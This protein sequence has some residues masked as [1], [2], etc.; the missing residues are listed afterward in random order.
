[1][2]VRHDMEGQK[3]SQ[4]QPS[5]ASLLPAWPPDW[6]E[7][8]AAVEV[9]LREGTWG[10]YRGP[11]ALE[12]RRVLASI[13]RES[14]GDVQQGVDMAREPDAEHCRLVSSGSLGVEL[15][16]RGLGIQAGD[17]VAVCGYD[18]PG[19]V[20]A[21]EAAGARPVLI[22]ADPNGNSLCP[23]KLAKMADSRPQDVQAV[24]VSHL[25]GVPAH[26]AEIS[27]ICRQ[28]EWSLVEDACQ[29]PGGIIE[30]R[31]AGGWGD[32]GVLSFGGSKPLTAGCGGA[33][34][35]K[36][37]QIH[38]R[39]NRWCDRPSDS[40]ALSEMQATLLLPQLARLPECDSIRHETIQA[41]LSQV[42]WTSS[43]LCGPPPSITCYKLAWLIDERER[44]VN[45]LIDRGIPAGVGYRS[46]HRSR[47]FDR[48][49]SLRRSIELG[50]RVVVLDHRALLAEGDARTWLL[51]QLIEVGKKLQL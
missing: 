2:Q 15:A 40:T 13:T 29:T 25:Y 31:P 17:R 24:I 39:L 33:L 49:E 3:Q 5:D 11:A 38:S 16:L 9:A 10:R 45:E 12:L 34:I 1:M 43:R 23:R 36:S 8:R 47:R 51:K 41:I 37:P 14:V 42:P 48:F 19:N 21:I 26:V 28:Y 50:E 46:M 6:P 7:V 35:S 32:A 4:A 20:R 27:E 22:D 18:Y 30:G 44:L